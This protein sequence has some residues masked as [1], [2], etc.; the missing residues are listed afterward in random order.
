M[1]SWSQYYLHTFVQISKLGL[2]DN[3]KINLRLLWS[4]G[5]THHFSNQST[6]PLGFLSLW[7]YL[8]QA[9]EEQ[10]RSFRTLSTKTDIKLSSSEFVVLFH[11][12][13]ERLQPIK[14]RIEYKRFKVHRLTN[15]LFVEYLLESVLSNLWRQIWP[16]L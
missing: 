5:T 3:C 4:S 15:A 14:L 6:Q 7:E 10:F 2:G 11:K 9:M 16:L 13:L 1:I 8:K 12:T